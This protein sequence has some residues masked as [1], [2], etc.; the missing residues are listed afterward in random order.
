MLFLLHLE[1]KKYFSHFFS[2]RAIFSTG[3]LG[4]MILPHVF[5]ISKAKHQDFQLE[6]NSLYSILN[7]IQLVFTIA[8]DYFAS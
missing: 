6:T 4:G 1:W 8:K 7:R 5:L 3:L 2:S